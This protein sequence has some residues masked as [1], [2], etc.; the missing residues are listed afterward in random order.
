[1]DLPRRECTVSLRTPVKHVVIRISFPAN[2]PHNESPKF[3][4]VRTNVDPDSLN[5]LKNVSIFYFPFYALDALQL[6]S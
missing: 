2:Y 6:L 1:M 5:K 4:F 3:V